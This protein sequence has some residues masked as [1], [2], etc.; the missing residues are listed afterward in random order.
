MLAHPVRATFCASLLLTFPLSVFSAAAEPPLLEELDFLREAN[1]ILEEEIKL[2]SSPQI[3][4]LLDLSEQVISIKG[5]GIELRR[6]PILAWSAPDQNALT[7]VFHLRARPPVE[8]P[9]AAPAGDSLPDPINLQD[10]PLEYVLLF[11]PALAIVVSPPVAEQPWFWMKSVVKEW[12]A[13]ARS[14]LQSAT[15]PDRIANGPR[16]RLT[17]S[18]E[19]AQSLAWSV[20]D[21]MPLLIGR[22]RGRI[23]QP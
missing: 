2:A 11:E 9:R 20:T 4:L 10:M 6:L 16:I 14:R 13:R 3:Y 12:W 19:A 21:G 18:Q 22:P 15:G 8:R 23:A 1:R 17:L 5:R 7:G